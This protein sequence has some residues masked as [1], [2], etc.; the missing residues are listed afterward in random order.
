MVWKLLYDKS[1]VDLISYVKD[2]IASHRDVQIFI[3]TDSQNKSSTSHYAMVIVLYNQGKGGHVL[4]SKQIIPRIKDRI[5][6]LLKEVELSI[7]VAGLLREAGIS[8][9]LTIDLDLNPDNKYMSN[10]IL[11]SALGWCVSMGYEVRHKP[12]AWSASYASDRLVKS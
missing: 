6:R 4:Y 10:K 12:D 5:Q 1:E 2:Y 7:E 3:G 9:T 8:R 11:T